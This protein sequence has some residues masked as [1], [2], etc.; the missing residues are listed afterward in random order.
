MTAPVADR[1]GTYEITGKKVARLGFG[2]MRLT[3]L[4]FRG[5]PED[6]PVAPGTSG[7]RRG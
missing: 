1:V 2:A 4:G 7:S 5:E 3:G 6:R